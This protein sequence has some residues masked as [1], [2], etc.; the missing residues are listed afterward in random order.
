MAESERKLLPSDKRHLK[1]F[2]L[3]VTDRKEPDRIPIS[4]FF[5]PSD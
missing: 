1:T 4:L 5:S 2:L 3:Q